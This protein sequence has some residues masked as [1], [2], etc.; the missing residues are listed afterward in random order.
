MTA[1]YYA[2]GVIVFVTAILVSIG[3]HEFGHLVPAK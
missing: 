3:L 1:L 2:L